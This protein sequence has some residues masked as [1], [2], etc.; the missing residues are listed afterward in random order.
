[1]HLTKELIKLKFQHCGVL[2]RLGQHSEAQKVCME[3]FQVMENY[4]NELLK[5]TRIHLNSAPPT[6]T[7]SSQESVL[8]LSSVSVFAEMTIKKLLSEIQ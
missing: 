7:K 2:S 8:F 6:P 5:I 4:L 1:M 3:N